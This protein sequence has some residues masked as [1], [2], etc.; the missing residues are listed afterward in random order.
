MWVSDSVDAVRDADAFAAAY[1]A[2]HDPPESPD[3]LS[4]DEAANIDRM[5]DGL[6][7]RQRG[8]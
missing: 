4:A 5:E 2:L 6:F 3:V 1:V 7:R 8:W